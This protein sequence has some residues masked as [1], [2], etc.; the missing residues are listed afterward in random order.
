[1]LVGRACLD[2]RSSGGQADDAKGGAQ[3]IDIFNSPRIRYFGV[4]IAL[5]EGGKGPYKVTALKST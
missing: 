2:L 3:D 1:M 5:I 4:L